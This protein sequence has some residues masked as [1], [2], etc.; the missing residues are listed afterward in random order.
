MSLEITNMTATD[1]KAKSKDTGT[2]VMTLI[3]LKV[4]T[5]LRMKRLN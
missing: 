1:A 3:L 2:K 5:S 4:V